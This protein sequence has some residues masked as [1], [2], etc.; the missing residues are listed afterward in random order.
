MTLLYDVE[1]YIERLGE[2]DDYFDP[3][4]AAED[5]G[6]AVEER[7]IFLG[8]VRWGHLEGTVF[9]RRESPGW[10]IAPKFEYVMVTEYCYSGDSDG[11]LELSASAV[12]PRTETT[13]VW[14]SL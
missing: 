14:D 13:V 6:A 1:T 11:D 2:N 4:D 10:P 9:C 7:N 3:D 8:S 12:T 5:L